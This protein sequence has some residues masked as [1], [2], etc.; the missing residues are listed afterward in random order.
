MQIQPQYATIQIEIQMSN[1]SSVF[2]FWLRT[3][4]AYQNS[5]I[6]LRRWSCG[7]CISQAFLLEIGICMNIVADCTQNASH[8]VIQVFMLHETKCNVKLHATWRPAWNKMQNNKVDCL[9]FE[10]CHDQRAKKALLQ[11]LDVHG[12]TIRIC[13]RLAHFLDACD[14]VNLPHRLP[15]IYSVVA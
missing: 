8:S 5:N 11:V 15:C 14:I 2:A 1:S 7:N 12:S 6:R 9:K 13:V 4:N 3:A 10:D